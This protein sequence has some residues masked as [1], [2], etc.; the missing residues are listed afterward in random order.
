MGCHLPTK[1]LSTNPAST[2]PSWSKTTKILCVGPTAAAAGGCTATFSASP[3]W[4]WLAAIRLLLHLFCLLSLRNPQAL[5]SWLQLHLH[6]F[7]LCNLWVCLLSIFI[8]CVQP[9][10]GNGTRHGQQQKRHCLAVAFRLALENPL[11]FSL[12][13]SANAGYLLQI[14]SETEIWKHVSGISNK[15]NCRLSSSRLRCLRFTLLSS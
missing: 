1:S 11:E 4:F 5:E 7:F 13:S 15:I 2:K 14:H 9:L 12:A 8:L 3:L 10:E 6:L